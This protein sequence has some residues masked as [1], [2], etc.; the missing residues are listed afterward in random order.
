MS[1]SFASEF[2]FSLIVVPALLLWR[3]GRAGGLGQRSS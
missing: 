3:A 2:L 1:I